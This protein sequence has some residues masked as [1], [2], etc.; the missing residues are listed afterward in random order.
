MGEFRDKERIRHI[1]A[2]IEYFRKIGKK[3]KEPKESFLRGKWSQISELIS[4][5]MDEPYIDDQVRIDTK[6]N[7]N[8]YRAKI[9]VPIYK[10]NK[11]R[12]KIVVM[13]WDL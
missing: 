12:Q 10:A 9:C 11:P 5:L 4:E 6:A 13:C 2:L 1:N 8:V 7:V 3:E